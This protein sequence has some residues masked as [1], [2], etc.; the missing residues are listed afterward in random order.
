MR[1][2]R[3]GGWEDARHVPAGSLGGQDEHLD[4][5]FVRA[6]TA[7]QGGMAFGGGNQLQRGQGGERAMRSSCSGGRKGKL[8]SAMTEY[9]Y[10]LA[11]VEPLCSHTL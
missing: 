3:G 5:G 2:R 6:P 10:G 9:T 1:R 11:L 8:V 4:L 7:L